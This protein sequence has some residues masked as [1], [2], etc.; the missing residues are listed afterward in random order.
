MLEADTIMRGIKDMK[1][2]I[3]IVF[4]I[5]I[6]SILASCSPIACNHKRIKEWTTII[7]PTCTLDG[8]EEG[9]CKVCG[10]TISRV[11]PAKGH[12]YEWTTII[13]PTCTSSGMRGECC[14]V[15]RFLSRTERVSPTEH[16][17]SAWTIVFEPTCTLDGMEDRHCEVCDKIE[18]RVIPSTGHTWGKWTTIVEPTCTSSGKEERH[19]PVCDETASRVIPATEHTFTYEF[20]ESEFTAYCSKCGNTTTRSFD[21][22]V[23][24]SG[25]T[26][27]HM[28]GTPLYSYC[29]Y[30]NSYFYYENIQIH[31]FE[32]RVRA[33]H[34]YGE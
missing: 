32:W 2:W 17:W 8:E 3:V 26:I 13:E 30:D 14:T 18:I 29:S 34:W 16:T 22:L 20:T 10:E 33:V 5:L 25:D 9:H 11:I 4:T 7:E 12:T 23:G 21:S 27:E 19:C 15:C 31:L 1:K 28:L 24:E 6:V